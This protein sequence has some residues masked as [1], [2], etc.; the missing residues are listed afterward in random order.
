MP[1]NLHFVMILLRKA[2]TL[3]SPLGL[4]HVHRHELALCRSSSAAYRYANQGSECSRAP[5]IGLQTTVGSLTS[6]QGTTR[7][8]HRQKAEGMISERSASPK[9]QAAA[10]GLR[11]LSAYQT[12]AHTPIMSLIT[13]KGRCTV[14]MQRRIDHRPA[15]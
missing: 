10:T 8:K 1:P 3:G 4:G 14:G 7:G 9:R 12:A 13:L 5:R 6:G 15:L 11:A 2:K